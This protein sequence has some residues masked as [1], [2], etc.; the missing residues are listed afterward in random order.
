MRT[1][2]GLFL[3]DDKKA[4]DNFGAI[5]DHIRGLLERHGASVDKL[6][7][8]DSRRLAYEIAGKRRGTYVLTKFSADP[9]KIAEL[10]RDCRISSVIMRALVLRTENVGEPMDTGD[11]R[12]RPR[13]PKVEPQ[14]KAEAPQQPKVE[15]ETAP[16]QPEQAEAQA[17]PAPETQPEP[18][19]QAP[20]DAA[21]EPSGEAETPA[22]AP[23][24]G[25]TPEAGPPAQEKPT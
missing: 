1:Y 5:A 23:P 7:K 14:P 18:A 6:E 9:A 8:W 3:V 2:E 22:T 13:R 10:K 24:E 19:R 21:S 16:A 4:S 25:A 11:D 12:R 20:T 17:A 15:Q